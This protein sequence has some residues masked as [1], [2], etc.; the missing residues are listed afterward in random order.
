MYTYKFLGLNKE[1]APTPYYY[2]SLPAK[3]ERGHILVYNEFGNRYAIYQVDG[4]GLVGEDAYANEKELA[5]AEI[6]RRETVPT[7][8]LQK[9]DTGKTDFRGRSFDA[10]EVKAWS[11]ENRKYRIA[12]PSQ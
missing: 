2:G 3:P 4:E 1:D 9:L 8:W 10:D 5:W 7:L 12:N 11:Q 6:G